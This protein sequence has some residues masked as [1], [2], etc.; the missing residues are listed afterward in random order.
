MKANGGKCGICG[1]DVKNRRPRPNENGGT[2][3]KGFIAKSYQEGSTIN[4]T[5]KVAVSH[6]GRFNYEYVFV[7]IIYY[8]IYTLNKQNT[9]KQKRSFTDKTMSSY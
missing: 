5:M 7:L 6:G 4:V 2:F 8:L 1:D 9:R 3:G